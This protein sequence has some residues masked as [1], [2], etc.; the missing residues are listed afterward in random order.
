MVSN[1][2]CIPRPDFIEQHIKNRV[3]GVFLVGSSILISKNIEEKITKEFI[4][5]SKIFESIWLKKVGLNL[6]VKRFLITSNGLVAFFLDTISSTEKILKN[7]NLSFWKSDFEKVAEF[8]SPLVNS[9]ESSVLISKNI[10]FRAI[11]LKMSN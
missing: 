9:L 10:K 8:D 3:E 6:F 11:L 5:S 4:Y 7:D 1:A 2:D